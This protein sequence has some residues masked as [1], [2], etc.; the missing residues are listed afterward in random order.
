MA[1]P[2]DKAEHRLTSVGRDVLANVALLY[3]KEGLM[4]SEIATRIKVSRATVVNYLRMAR[5]QRIVDIRINGEAFASSKLSRDLRETFGLEDVYVADVEDAGEH[6][7]PRRDR[8]NRVVARVGAMAL[9]DVVQPGDTLGVA[10]GETINLLAEELPH[11]EVPSVTVCQLVGSMKSPLVSASESCAI[12]IAS[13][14]GAECNTLH[15]PAILSTRALAEGLRAEPV[16]HAQ[17]AQLKGLTKAIFSVGNCQKDTHIIRSGIVTETDV[18]WYKSKGAV[19]VLCARFIN[20]EGEP[21]EGE[22]DERMIGIHLADLRDRE[23]GIL[24]AGGASKLHA[25]K[26]AIKGRYVSHL[27]IDRPTGLKLLADAPA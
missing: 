12:R 10:W 24:V 11:G 1:R 23:R 18:E 15:A 22:P 2:K 9:H 5:E 6:S 3:Y 26:A 19:G 27:V 16:I 8:T 13:R 17:L 20:A 7:K 14:L 4:Q 25:I 21:I